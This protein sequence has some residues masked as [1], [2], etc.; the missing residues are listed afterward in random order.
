[1]NIN[2]YTIDEI[3]FAEK[4]FKA[5][6]WSLDN[7]GLGKTL[8]D[9][10]SFEHLPLL[11]ALDKENYDV[12]DSRLFWQ[13]LCNLMKYRE[14]DIKMKLLSLLNKSDDIKIEVKA[15]KKK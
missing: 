14:H 6:L 10:R 7:N 11:G 15:K 2:G 12:D 3:L 5:L 13:V 8:E 4:F 1:M 9:I